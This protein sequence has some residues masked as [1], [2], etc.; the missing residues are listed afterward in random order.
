MADKE[1]RQKR[2][3]P[4]FFSTLLG[5]LFLIFVLSSGMLG[6]LLG[7]NA[8]R[9]TGELVDT[10]VLSPGDSSSRSQAALHFLTGRL[11]DRENNP[12]AGCTV[13]L[14]DSGREDVT[15]E[16]GKFYFPDLHSGE[17]T[18]ALLDSAGEPL[19]STRL[20]LNFSQ[21]A[22]V[23]AAFSSEGPSFQMPED[24]RVVELTL[25]VEEDHSLTVQED[26]ACFVT[27]DGQIVNFDGS[28]LRV[29]ESAKAVTPNGSVVDSTG[30]VLV[31]FQN[32][33]LTP[34][35]VQEEAVPGQ[36][37]APGA[38]TEADGTVVLMDHTSLLPGGEVL[39]PDG[40]TVVGGGEKVVVVENG[41]AEELDQLPDI[42]TPEIPQDAAG[43]S[44]QTAEAHPAAEE[45][46]P[47]ES[48]SGESSAAESPEEPEPAESYRGLE[49]MDAETNIAWRQQSMIDLFKNRPGSSYIDEKDGLSIVQPGS[50][51]YYEFRLENPEE[52]DIA[53]T[54]AIQ[55]QSFHLP[56][57]YTLADEENNH[58]YVHRQRSGMEEK[59]TS[60]K[61]VIPAGTEQNF[62]IE[63]EWQYEDWY[64]P[65]RDNALDTA[66]AV[67]AD[68][69]YM[70][71]I[72]INAAQIERPNT[73]VGDGDTRYP[74]QH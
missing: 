16:Q 60:P 62:R 21:K 49:I 28:A 40:E 15:D 29:R 70:I 65:D 27:K 25:T 38:V 36:E 11:V 48:S 12:C 14:G 47:G 56:M 32:V 35:G 61:I 44:G 5:I 67:R 17:Y 51:G 53:Y 55:E 10:I 42:Y 26:S 23:S 68:R 8:S 46:Q 30:Y 69:T 1:N 57:L 71:A 33:V 2:G 41:G 6:Y 7:R 54:I 50:K 52:F 59:L 64:D 9:S 63:W 24:T 58:H 37:A 22:D 45:E 20:S 39:L 66:A 13:R 18:F 74:G 43:G 73:T 4:S 3:C 72:F 19:S 31:P 34:A